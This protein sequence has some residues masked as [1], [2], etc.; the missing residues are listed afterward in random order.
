MH[1]ILFSFSQL[2]LIINSH[3]NMLCNGTKCDVATLLN[4]K[5]Q[6]ECVLQSKSTDLM[7]KFLDIQI[8][9]FLF[10]NRHSMAQK[11]LQ[12]YLQLKLYLISMGKADRNNFPL[13]YGETFLDESSCS[14]SVR[15][16]SWQEKKNWLKFCLAS[17][18][19]LSV[20]YMEYLQ[21]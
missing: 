20:G 17:G 15:G 9:R 11:V 19:G 14:C 6:Q 13:S 5:P 1:R 3:R 21:W 10:S 8:K 18:Y 16:V 12:K 7:E 2:M 4:R